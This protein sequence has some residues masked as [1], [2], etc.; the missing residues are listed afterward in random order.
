MPPDH[1]KKAAPEMAL[2]GVLEKFPE[3]GA[4]IRQ[5]F[6]ENSSFQSLCEDYR[7][8]LAAWQ[9][10]RQAISEEAPALCQSYA[11]LLRELD[12]EIRDYLEHEEASGP[13]L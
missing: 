12:Q 5:L 3:A 2:A 13:N 9:H 10:W 8:C 1:R 4:K 7:D 11:K 6:Q